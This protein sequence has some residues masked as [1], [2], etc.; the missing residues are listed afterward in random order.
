MKSL[1]RFVYIFGGIIA[2]CGFPPFF[3]F[4]CFLLAVGWLFYKIC[5]TKTWNKR[6]AIDILLFWTAFFS[7]NLYWLAI[8]LTFDIKQ[9]WF[10]IPFALF[11]IPIVLSLYMIPA[12]YY[13]WKFRKNIFLSG[14][15]FSVGNF[16]ATIVYGKIC[17]AF[18][19]VLPGYI[20]NSF[21]SSMQLLSV[22]GIYGQTFI[23]FV[24][25]S[26]FGI[27]FAQYR[28]KKRYI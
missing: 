12:G 15:I 2:A 20:W 9:Y 1:R 5:E 24:I 25:C 8:P 10:L 23:T 11:A 4:P 27:S 18:P 17:P 26:L 28:R 14:A 22:W 21:D 19:W 16:L 7:A 13:A 6:V 3:I